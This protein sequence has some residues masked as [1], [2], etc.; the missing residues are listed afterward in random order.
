MHFLND[1]LRYTFRSRRFNSEI[2]DVQEAGPAEIGYSDIWEDYKDDIEFCYFEEAN[3]VEG[4]ANGLN[5]GMNA[6]IE[7]LYNTGKPYWQSWHLY[8]DDDNVRLVVSMADNSKNVIFDYKRD[9]DSLD[10]DTVYEIEKCLAG[11]DLNE[12]C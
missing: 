8:T 12:A 10:E 1:Y 9:K 11:P 4:Q 5:K 7:M 2:F 6:M 3:Y